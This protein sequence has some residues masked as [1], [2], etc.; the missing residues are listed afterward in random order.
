MTSNSVE[1]TLFATD[2]S[3]L[4]RRREAIIEPELPIVDPHHHLWDRG[5]RY[6]LEEVLAVLNTGHRV[7]ATVFLQ[8]DSMYR[9][10]GD[11]VLRPVGETEF[12]NGIAAAAASGTYG[13]TKVC[14]GIVGFADLYLGSEVDRI[15]E[16]HLSRGGERFK[17]VRHC[18]VWDADQ[19]IKS[20]PMGFPKGVLMDDKFRAGFARLS[21][22]GLSFDGWLYHTQVPEFTDLARA[23]PETTMILD[24][25]GAPLAIGAYANKRAEVFADWKKSMRD[26]ATCPNANVKLGGLGMHVFGFGYDHA[27]DP[28]SSEI[29]ATAWR[30]YVET[31]IELFG[32]GR[33]MFESNFPVDKRSCSYHVLWNA[34][35][36]LASSASATE[37]ALLFKDTAIR[38]YRL[39]GV[40]RGSSL[41][42]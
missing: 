38:V 41:S 22:Y 8:C 3:W 25:V 42:G 37:K 40:E 23:F 12:V 7:L 6:L 9:V 17:G 2:Q 20:T 15:L 26:L 5:A 29:L 34:F 21:R 10:D 11:H 24:H 36:R 4:D 33:C 27:P 30:P 35:K 14:D 19:T 31:C 32:P 16:L 28:V 1:K 39:G 13:P 18:S